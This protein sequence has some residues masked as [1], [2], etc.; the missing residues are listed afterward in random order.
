[1]QIFQ[2]DLSR[3]LTVIPT[4]QDFEPLPC[5]CRMRGNDVCGYNKMCSNS[6]AVHK[7]KCNNTGKMCI[8]N[9]QQKFKAR[10]QQCFN[11]VKK[12]VNRGEKSDSDAEHFA[13]Q[14]HDTNM[15]A[16]TSSCWWV[17]QKNTTRAQRLRIS[18][19]SAS[20]W[21][22]ITS[23]PMWRNNLQHHLARQSNWCSQNFRYQ[24][25]RPVCQRKN[26]NS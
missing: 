21:T 7:V 26:C 15:A 13:T 24:K 5:N 14:F 22:P 2:R 12:L 23:Q 16:L 11:K 8:G 17:L 9:T 18:Q 1:M 19:S 10:I 4:S 25:M 6:T 20:W 3:K